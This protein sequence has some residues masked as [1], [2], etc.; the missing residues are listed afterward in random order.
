[1]NATYAFLVIV[2]KSQNLRGNLQGN[3]SLQMSK[4]SVAIHKKRK[5]KNT[6][7][8]TLNQF[9]Q[10]KCNEVSLAMTILGYCDL[11][12]TKDTHPQTPSA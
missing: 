9:S 6:L 5:K 8:R 2:G 10:N 11:D 3:S 1:M 4:A 12:S 7:P